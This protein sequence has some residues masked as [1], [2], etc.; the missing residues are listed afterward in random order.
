MEQNKTGKYLKYAVGEIVLVMVGIL[1]ALQVNNWNEGRK[2]QRKAKTHLASIRADLIQDIED[3]NRKTFWW[4]RVWCF[5]ELYPDFKLPSRLDSITPTK[6]SCNITYNQMFN[7]GSSFRSNTGAFDAMI[8]DG[9]ANLISNKTIFAKI[10]NLY[11][12]WNPALLNYFNNN[13]TQSSNLK[14]KYGQLITYEPNTN[15]TETKDSKL[16]ADITVYFTDLRFFTTQLARV[17]QLINETI[18]EID[19]ELNK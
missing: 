10:Q 9:S 6:T 7:Y 4:S 14:Y 15:I 17:K 3:I 13:R 12:F 8:S 11:K 5:K 2:S 1:L 19:A 18:S 16:I